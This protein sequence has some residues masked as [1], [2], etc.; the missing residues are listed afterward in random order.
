MMSQDKSTV[1]LRAKLV[2][3]PAVLCEVGGLLS[4]MDRDLQTRT[5]FLSQAATEC[6]TA[7]EAHRHSLA[8]NHLGTLV[9]W[10]TMDGI[11]GQLLDAIH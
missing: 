3:W 4:Q 6:T 5:A 10:D 11:I 7:E 2:F 1:E 9:R 8:W